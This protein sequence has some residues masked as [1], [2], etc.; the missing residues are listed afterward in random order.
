MEALT[1]AVAHMEEALM[2]VAP[3]TAVGTLVSKAVDILTVVLAAEVTFRPLAWEAG[4]RATDERLVARTQS[5]EDFLLAPLA[6][7]RTILTQ[8]GKASTRH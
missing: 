1:E 5:P 8:A 4:S 7:S 6:I 2:G 3:S